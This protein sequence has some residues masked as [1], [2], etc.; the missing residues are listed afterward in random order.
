[1]NTFS[2]KLACVYNMYA[3]PPPPNMLLIDSEGPRSCLRLISLRLNLFK[4]LS[5][6]FIVWNYHARS[7]TCS[8]IVITSKRRGRDSFRKLHPKNEVRSN[9]LHNFPPYLYNV[10]CIIFRVYRSYSILQNLSLLFF[11]SFFF[12]QQQSFKY[13]T[14][15]D[16]YIY[17]T[18][19]MKHISHRTGIKPARFI[20]VI[21]QFLCVTSFICRYKH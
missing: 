10:R 2:T 6:A 4:D 8:L 21:T 11:F 12:F 15:S 7:T 16:V 14:Q 9:R 5:S 1:M 17:K 3:T 18:I 19:S 13:E 20:I